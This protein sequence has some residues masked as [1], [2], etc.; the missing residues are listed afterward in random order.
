MALRWGAAIVAALAVGCVPL[1]G[2]PLD[3]GGTD[4]GNDSAL[5][6]SWLVDEADPPGQPLNTFVAGR[7]RISSI[8]DTR[9]ICFRFSSISSMEGA[10]NVNHTLY[11]L[12][13]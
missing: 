2:D 8:P 12:S 9:A 3:E 4:A 13:R 1:N 11:V 5:D 10:I 7:L 6:C